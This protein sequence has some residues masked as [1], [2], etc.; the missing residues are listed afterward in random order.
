MSDFN[1]GLYDLNNTPIK[2]GDRIRIEWKEGFHKG[3]IYEVDVHFNDGVVGSQQN[4]LKTLTSGIW[5][6]IGLNHDG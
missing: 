5:L 1:T 4:K 6:M 3:L 2:I